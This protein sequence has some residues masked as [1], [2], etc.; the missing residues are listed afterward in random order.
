[1]QG[2]LLLLLLLGSDWPLSRS[3]SR[4]AAPS[5]SLIVILVLFMFTMLLFY[6]VLLPRNLSCPLLFHIVFRRPTN[7]PSHTLYVC[8]P[9][10]MLWFDAVWSYE[11][12]RLVSR[13]L[14]GRRTSGYVASWPSHGLW[15]VRP[16]ATRS[17][18]ISRLCTPEGSSLIA[19][20]VRGWGLVRLHSCFPFIPFPV[21]YLHLSLHCISFFLLCLL[22]YFFRTGFRVIIFFSYFSFCIAFFCVS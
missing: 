21:L 4:R 22:S 19:G 17:S 2:E 14:L 1:M 7:I 9:V 13:H 18:V 20:W 12:R 15:P 5:S 16:T 3:H 6:Y 11:P 10:L 8:P